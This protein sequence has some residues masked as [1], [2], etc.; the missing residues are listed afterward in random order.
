MTVTI[1]IFIRILRHNEF[2]IAGEILFGA[3]LIGSLLFHSLMFIM[4]TFIILLLWQK[5]PIS[6]LHQCYGLPL[7]NNSKRNILPFFSDLWSKERRDVKD[8]VGKISSNAILSSQHMISVTPKVEVISTK[9]LTK[10]DNL[11][12]ANVIF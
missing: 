12:T 7:Y 11:S 4:K 6:N 1:F 2:S 3:V 8:S 5:V 10:C 9:K